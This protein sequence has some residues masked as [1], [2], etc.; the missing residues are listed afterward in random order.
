M[1]ASGEKPIVIKS[2]FGKSKFGNREERAER[3]TFEQTYFV[4]KKQKIY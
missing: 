2:R 3:E 4:K 1:Y